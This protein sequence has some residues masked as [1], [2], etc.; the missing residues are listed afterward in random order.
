MSSAPDDIDAWL[1]DLGLGVYVDA[2]RDNGVD[3]ELLLE[4]TND[5]LKD[6]SVSR[7]KDRKTLLKAIDSLRTPAP[8]AVPEAE[9]RQLT[10]MFC[11]L[12]GSTELST[13]FDPED[14]RKLIVS[15]QDSCR[16]AIE[17]FDG[18]IAR[19]M[20]DGILV[21]FG[22]PQAHE[23]SAERAVRAGL[24]ITQSMAQLNQQIDRSLG[25]KL[26]VRI[27]IATG[28]VV[29]GDIVGKGA[30]EE[31]AVVGETPNLAARLQGIAEPDQLV[32]AASTQKLLGALFDYE[33]LGTHQLK[34]LAKPVRAYRV[35]RARDVDSRFIAKHER[36][37]DPLINRHD[38]MKL[39]LD[40]WKRCKG[41]HGRAVVI[42]G[43][44]GIGKSKIC[45]ALEDRIADEAHNLLRIQCSPFH[46]NSTLYPIAEQIRAEAG[47]SRDRT[48]EDN[49]DRLDRLLA[50]ASVDGVRM[51]ELVAP[52]LSIPTGD[53]FAAP[54]LSPARRKALT[55]EALMRRLA[56]LDDENP[57]TI[58]LE[59]LHWVDP[60]TME[61]LDLLVSRLDEVN[62]LKVVTHRPEFDV[63][64]RDSRNVQTITLDRLGSEH[65]VELV[66]QRQ[67]NFELPADAV[68]EILAKTDGVPLFVEEL[69]SMLIERARQSS[70]GDGV[71]LTSIPT[72]IHDLLLAR[73]DQ[74]GPAKKIAQQA[75]CFGRTFSI[76]RLVQVID[77]PREEIGSHLKALVTSRLAAATATPGEYSFRHALI[78][79]AAYD[80]LLRA[81]RIELHRRIA[82]SLEAELAV[83]EPEILAHHFGRAELFEQE[84][85]YWQRAGLKAM[86]ASAF[87]EASSHLRNAINRLDKLPED[88]RLEKD[89]ELHVQ[90]AVP[91]TL[92]LGWAAQ[93]VRLVYERAYDLCQQLDDSPLLYPVLHGMFRYYLVNADHAAAE[94]IAERDLERA[95]ATGDDGIILEFTLHPGVVRFYTG[96]MTEALPYLARCVELY[97][98]EKHRDHTEAYAACPATIATAH[99]ANALAVMGRPDEAF[100][101]NRRCAVFAGQTGH[102]F[103]RIWSMSNHA[104]NHILVSRLCRGRRSCR[105]NDCRCRRTGLR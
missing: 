96:R 37:S 8:R 24:V 39:L 44:A 63:P 55:L 71:A 79:E 1:H 4:L 7:L 9:R 12:V 80:S 29:V 59:D 43:E 98:V 105:T 33:D 73:L 67:R 70:H 91:L 87:L 66:R 78:Q 72:T 68:D 32:V 31:A 62:L 22:Y 103:S 14:L 16:P 92:T 69:T 11:D 82:E 38:E 21:Y 5:D 56:T 20:G 18:F 17:R 50:G 46:S 94:Q 25:A 86:G 35:V 95:T 74:L 54:D 19:Y 64:W 83:Q 65:V 84:V 13:R 6:L 100:D 34:G 27:G 49:L 48:V 58:I 104:M 60:T 10:V 28:P 99:Q 26:A 51:T 97:D 57:L 52:L 93:D 47:I 61:F 40:A 90:I 81:S 15:F 45:E 42:C 102:V 77:T 88:G 85:A 3:A 30:A 76:D 75:A 41:R 2:F 101:S 36:T 89:L 53:R 23:D